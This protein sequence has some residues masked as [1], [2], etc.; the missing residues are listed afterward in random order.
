MEFFVKKEMQKSA[1][2]RAARRRRRR[3]KRLYLLTA[4]F[5]TLC[6]FA[7][8]GVIVLANRSGGNDKAW[9]S[10][11]RHVEIAAP[12][13]AAAGG[14]IADTPDPALPTFPPV[15]WSEATPEATQEPEMQSTPEATQPPQAEITPEPEAQMPSLEAEAQ[16]T[17]I[18]ITAAGD[19]TLGG[20]YNTSAH[21]RF[22]GC[23][24]AYGVDY[25]LQNVRSIFEGDDLT[26]VN[27]EGPLTTEEEKRGGRIFNFKGDPSY[28]QILA[29]SS[30]EV[31]GLANN[32][33]LDF[34]KA[35]LLQTA[36][37][38][39]D[40][41]VGYCGYQSVWRTE[42]KGVSISCISVTEWDYTEAELAEMVQTARAESDL[43][44]VMIHWGEEKVYSATDSQTSYGHALIDAG[45]DLVVGSHPHVVGGVE[46]YKG[47]YI[48]YSLG[49]FCFGGNSNPKD[50][51]CMLFQQTFLVG[52]GS[53]SDGGICVIPC[54]ISSSAS[55][56][57][58]QP[59]PLTGDEAARVLRKI[60]AYSKLNAD[61]VRWADAMKPYLAALQ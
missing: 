31:A 7:L 32:H 14:A 52:N 51:D 18:T 58:Y 17:S 56:N 12:G 53:V 34:R 4:V 49:N 16:L 15:G 22:D 61:Q 35:G 20:D 19:M 5:A 37:V 57:N 27:L 26:F 54:S 33:A 8:I 29:G 50:K 55:T 47:K 42:V 3:E 21:E 10:G 30:V 36:Q 43:V 59:T 40:A 6:V 39:E 13:Y 44:L 41:G 46:Q 45:A 48:V 2:R 25:F 23:V 38:L 1:R 28:V 11:N 60:G 24:E 9:S